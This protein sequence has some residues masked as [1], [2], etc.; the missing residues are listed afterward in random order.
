MERPKYVFRQVV[1]CVGLWA[2]HLSIGCPMVCCTDDNASH[3]G[4]VLR[5]PMR[6]PMGRYYACGACHKTSY[7]LNFD[8]FDIPWAVPWNVPHVA[9]HPCVISRDVLGEHVIPL[10]VL[11]DDIIPMPRSPHRPSRGSSERYHAIPFLIRLRLM[12]YP[13]RR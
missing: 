1:S 3:H 7:G 12:D 11:R 13:I 4:R 2:V 6:R 8:A 5:C 10:E 9:M